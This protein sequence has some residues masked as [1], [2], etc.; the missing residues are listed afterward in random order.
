AQRRPVRG[1]AG[2]PVL[3]R[4]RQGQE[5]PGLGR[6]LARRCQGAQ[7]RG[8]R[9]PVPGAPRRRGAA[10]WPA[11]AARPGPGENVQ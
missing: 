5:A 1:G 10:P 11:R 9:R 7:G 4:L 3:P 2:E 8:P 6:R